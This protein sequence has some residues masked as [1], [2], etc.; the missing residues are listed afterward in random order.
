MLSTSALNSLTWYPLPQLSHRNTPT[1]NEYLKDGTALH[2]CGVLFNDAAVFVAETVRCKAVGSTG[3]S[4]LKFA[5]AKH[6][7]CIILVKNC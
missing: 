6:K 3:T 7:L 5:Y 4:T 2:M 1:C